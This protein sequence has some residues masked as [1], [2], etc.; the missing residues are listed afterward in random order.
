MMERLRDFLTNGGLILRSREAVEEMRAVTRDGDSIRAE[1]DDHDDRV[2]AVAMG[3]LCWE[4]HERKPLISMGRT[5]EFE[6]A[7]GRMSVQD[8]FTMLSKHQLNQFFKGKESDRRTA[9][10]QQRRDA[11]RLR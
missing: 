3:I 7:K 2:L 9:A 4:Q 11:W 8:Q 5:R 6:I 10:A 1:G